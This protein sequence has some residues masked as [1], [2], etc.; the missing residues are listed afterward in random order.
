VQ[1]GLAGEFTIDKPT[2]HRADVA[3]GCLDRHLRTQLFSAIRFASSAKPMPARAT[4]ISSWTQAP[5]GC[6]ILR[7]AASADPPSESKISQNGPNGSAA[8]R[9]RPSTTRSPH[10]LGDGGAI[11]LAACMAP[12]LVFLPTA[13]CVHRRDFR[14]RAKLSP[15]AGLFGTCVPKVTLRKV[16]NF[17][18]LSVDRSCN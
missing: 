6:S 9:S 10:Q 11:F 16:S 14:L 17:N 7:A 13:R 3:P 15:G 12:D 1:D 2:S 8:A 4:L 5:P 18:A